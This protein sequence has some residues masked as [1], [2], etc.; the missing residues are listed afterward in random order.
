VTSLALSVFTGVAAT[1]AAN[2]TAATRAHTSLSI[3]LANPSIN[4]GGSDAISGSLRASF[5]RVADRRIALQARAIGGASWLTAA[6]HRTGAR[7]QVGFEVTPAATTR[8][9][10]VFNGNE[11]QRPSVSGVVTVV[12]RNTTS[13]TIALA[14][15]SILPGGSD[16]ITGLLSYSGNPLVGETVV[17][18]GRR[19]GYAF[20]KIGSATTAADGSVTFTVMPHATTQ[21]VL[22]FAK[23]ATNAG[24]RSAVATVHVVRPSSLSI[25]AVQRLKT[26]SEVIS[27]SL[28]GGGTALPGRRVM[29]QDRPTGTTTWTTVATHRTNYKGAVSF[30]EPAPTASEDYQLVFLGGPLFQGCQSGVVTVTVA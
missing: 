2:A 17:L 8:Y 26:S 16:T 20:A 6:V 30:I 24:A 10:L 25:R 13:L 7:G 4:P 28:R 22:V 18:R 19:P 1:G 21:Y 23:T 3:R 12:V 9:R 27:G 14:S 15:G 5:G 29:L 11:V